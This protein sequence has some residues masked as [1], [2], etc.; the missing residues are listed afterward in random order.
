MRRPAM[1]PERPN[2]GRSIAA[3]LDDSA[4]LAGLL[5]GHKRSYACFAAAKSGM[6]AG[7]LS[8][9]R[10]GPIDEQAWTVFASTNGAAAKL[11]QCLPTMLAA[12]QTRDPQIME[13]RVKVAPLR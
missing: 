3:A 10:P 13:I 11:R 6:P 7:L 8:Q 5:A 4:T 2:L 12:V 9:V 1:R